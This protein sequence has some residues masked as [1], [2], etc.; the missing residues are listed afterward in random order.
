MVRTENR[1]TNLIEFKLS[2]NGITGDQNVEIFR[3]GKLLGTVEGRDE[4]ITVNSKFIGLVEDTTTL[5]GIF[6]TADGK[7]ASQITINLLPLP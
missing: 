3:N 4:M 5:R 6:L 7:I 2:K 1:V